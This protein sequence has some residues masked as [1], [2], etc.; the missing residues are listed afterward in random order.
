MLSYANSS[1][2]SPTSSNLPQVPS[3]HEPH[4]ASGFS[5]KR[6][7]KSSTS[8]AALPSTAPHTAIRTARS[9]TN[10][11]PSTPS[12][13]TSAPLSHSTSQ[14]HSTLSDAS[15]R[16]GGPTL[17]LLSFEGSDGAPADNG[18]FAE[19]LIRRLSH[20][21]ES[22]EYEQEDG[23]RTLD[24]RE[25]RRDPRSPQPDRS[26]GA[27]GEQEE[28]DGEGDGAEEVGSGL[29]HP[30]GVAASQQRMRA[31]ATL[32]VEEE[33]IELDFRCTSYSFLSSF[34]PRLT[35]ASLFRA[36][37]ITDLLV[38]LPLLPP[39]F[40]L[41]FDTNQI[42]ANASP[43]LTSR[44]SSSITWAISSSTSSE[45]TCSTSST[46]SGGSTSFLISR[47]TSDVSRRFLSSLFPSLSHLALSRV[48]RGRKRTGGEADASLCRFFVGVWIQWRTTAYSSVETLEAT[49]ASSCAPFWYVRPLDSTR[50]LDDIFIRCR[51]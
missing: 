7:N 34:F 16:D 27:P 23:D 9:T 44:A 37:T 29:H 5:F 45:A 21:N 4:K 47:S 24:G 26:F 6:S 17:S 46:R 42:G 25:R 31:T 32:P 41:V 2:S 15:S 30:Y 14:R 3:H 35:A 11:L 51:S 10:P 40:R 19:N 39:P 1:A 36:W 20:P 43:T 8:S 50:S 38:P 18:G 22:L 12:T 33:E 28:D 13:I 48:D 49:W